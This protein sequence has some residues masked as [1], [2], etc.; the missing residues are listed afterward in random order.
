MPETPSSALPHRTSG[1]LLLTTTGARSGRPHTVPLGCVRH[2]GRLLV[3]ASN[4]G[5]DRHPDWYHNLLARP[6]VTVEADG[7]TF[8][9]VALPAQGARRDALFAAVVRAA[10]GYAVHQA[11]TSRTLPVVILDRP[12]T[13]ATTTVTTLAGKL[14]QVH[15]WL[16]EQLE[17]VREETDAHFASPDASVPGLGLQIRQ[18]CLAFCQ[19]LEFHHDS[20]D[21]HLFPGIARWHPRLA[22]VFERL[23]AEHVEVARI[24]RSLAALLDDVANA[25]PRAFRTELDRMTKELT[26]HLDYEEEHLLP[27]LT[28]VPWPPRGA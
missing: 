24:Q 13:K 16:R 4:L 2:A 17:R 10:P 23:R 25:D 3:V 9:A 1:Q 26:A 15:I 8:Q 7:E 28:D 18:H 20:E 27:V 19:S 21:G 14:L 22:D 12:A 11:A 6:V 5:S